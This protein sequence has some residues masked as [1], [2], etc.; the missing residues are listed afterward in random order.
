MI[1]IKRIE[2]PEAELLLEYHRKIG[3]FEPRD[4]EVSSLEAG[5]VV[6]AGDGTIELVPCVRVVEHYGDAE[7]WNEN[8]DDPAYRHRDDYVVGYRYEPLITH[9]FA[10]YSNDDVELTIRNP[11][12]MGRRVN[13]LSLVDSLGQRKH[14]RRY[15]WTTEVSELPQKEKADTVPTSLN[16]APAKERENA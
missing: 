14:G 1:K 12:E 7:G 11:L 8:I 10:D 6:L 13:P 3:P 15:W 16:P 2:V 4:E 5:D 9:R